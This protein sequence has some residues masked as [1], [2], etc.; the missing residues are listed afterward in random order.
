MA[1]HIELERWDDAL[2]LGKQKAEL[3][4]IVKLPYASWLCS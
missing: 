4:E 2:L 3:M 1:L